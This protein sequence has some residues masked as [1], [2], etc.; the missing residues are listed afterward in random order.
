MNLSPETSTYTEVHVAELDPH[1]TAR[2]LKS[3]V[4]PRPIA[5]VGSIDA[6]GTHNL[7]PHSYF[8]MVSAVPP[9][10]LFSSIQAPSAAGA[11]KDTAANAASTGDF[12]ISLVSWDQHTGANQTSADLPP[13][14]SE[15]DDAGLTPLP[16]QL[17]RSPGV[18]GAPAMMECRLRHTEQLGDATVVFGDV[19][20]FR[21]NDDTLRDD[22]RGHRLPDATR[23][24]PVA[25]LGRN[26][27]ARLGEVFPLERP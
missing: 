16:S 26:E 15:F 17:V 25:R 13:Q 18:A 20:L 8:T 11:L 3:V 1:D 21:F 12:T 9:V 22:E 6:N 14:T 10:V 23:L 27:W 4:I 19:V 5:W 2:L 7:A 24:D